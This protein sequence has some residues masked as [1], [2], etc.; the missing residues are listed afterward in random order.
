M[1]LVASSIVGGFN[2]YGMVPAFWGA[3]ALA[4]LGMI[5]RALTRDAAQ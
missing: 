4:I 1:I 5:F 2:V 3:L